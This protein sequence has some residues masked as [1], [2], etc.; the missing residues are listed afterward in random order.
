[1]LDTEIARNVL[2]ELLWDESVDARKI[3]ATSN[4]GHVT[5]TG[6][7]VTYYDK[8]RAGED[9]CRIYGVRSVENNILVDLTAERQLDAELVV[10]A[11]KGLAANKLV[12]RGAVK[13]TAHDG[14]ITMAGNVEHHFQREAA[15]FVIRHLPNLRGYTDRLTVSHDPAGDISDRITQ[16]LV[17]SAAIDSGKIK[18]ADDAGVVTLTGTVRSYAEKQEAER[19]AWNAPGVTMVHDELAI[20]G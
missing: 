1:M 18:V 10:A 14:W 20:V 5:L 4:N 7:V 17:R 13:V 8:W 3:N 9:A 2:D 19:A 15:E 16:S 11:E 12:P 6:A